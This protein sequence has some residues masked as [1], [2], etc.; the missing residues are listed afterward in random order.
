VRDDFFRPGVVTGDE[1]R[2][3]ILKRPVCIALGRQML[4][5]DGVKS[6]YQA[7]FLQVRGQQFARCGL[8]SFQLRESAV[9]LRVVISGIDNNLALKSP[10]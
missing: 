9:A 5:I 8:V 7:R 6:F 10:S 2:A 4:E 3:S 1:Y